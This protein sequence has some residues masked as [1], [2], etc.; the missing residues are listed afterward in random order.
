MT[1]QSI[2]QEWS[3]PLANGLMSS[4]PKRK[5]SKNE[6]AAIKN[7]NLWLC[8]NCH[9]GIF[10]NKKIREESIKHNCSKYQNE[11]N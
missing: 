9:F 10:S 4:L 1:S 7:G 2:M 11:K 5:L 6:L 8:P 3:K